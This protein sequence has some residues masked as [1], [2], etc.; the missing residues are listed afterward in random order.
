MNMYNKTVQIKTVVQV[1]IGIV[2]GLIISSVLSFVL[3]FDFF[4]CLF[5]S[6][7]GIIFS[8]SFMK[9]GVS[10]YKSSYAVQQPN[11]VNLFQNSEV[12]GDDV[13]GQQ[14]KSTI[15]KKNKIDI[16]DWMKLDSIKLRVFIGV[17]LMVV[18]LF[19]YR[20]YFF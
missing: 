15:Y 16:L 8:C 7:V 6:A 11:N 2:Y 19:Q 17:L 20:G 4:T 5:L 13:F 1:M 14:N 18:V 10:Y 9:G 3:P 12:T